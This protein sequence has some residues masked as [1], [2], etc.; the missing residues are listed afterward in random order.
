MSDFTQDRFDDNK[1]HDLALD[2]SESEIK[3]TVDKAVLKAEV[4]NIFD[5]N[6]KNFEAYLG[7]YNREREELK[8]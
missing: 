1:K 8:T 2:F 3:L 6:A 4:D 5:Y 7:G